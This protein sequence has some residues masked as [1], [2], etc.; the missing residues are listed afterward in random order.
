MNKSAPLSL[1]DF[2]RIVRQDN[3]VHLLHNNK[4][5]DKNNT[6]PVTYLNFELVDEKD[7]KKYR[8]EIKITGMS[9]GKIKPPGNPPEGRGTYGPSFVM[10]KS[11]TVSQKILTLILLML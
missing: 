5:V 11:N 8:P 7:G 10:S 6:N 9:G 3:S 4:P 1:E 2:D